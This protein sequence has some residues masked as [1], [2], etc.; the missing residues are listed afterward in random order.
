VS[1]GRLEARA[2]RVHFQGVKAIDGVDLAVDQAEVLGLIGPN[3]AGKTTLVNV[4][5]G[6]QH[7]TTGTVA[8][9]GRDI[10][11]WGPAEIARAGLVRTF[12]GA[13]FFGGLTVFE[14]VE[15]AAVSAGASRRAARALAGELLAEMGIEEKARLPARALSHGEERKL[16]IAR[17]LALRPS[18]LLLDEPA[19]GLDLGAREA[20]VLRLARLAAD[21]TAP[22]IVLVSHH[23][24]EI[25]RGF[26]HA[27]LL[28]GG[29]VISAGRIDETL[30]GSS[31]SESYGLPLQIDRRDGRYAARVAIAVAVG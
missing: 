15:V 24:E 29:R 13:R 22:T 6:F 17:A 5:S 28:A 14:N 8:I 9:S 11:T 2:I 12:Q 16:G 26:T 23:V 21:P 20:L 25:P 18:F 4:L 3:G 10:T 7:A 31:M 30:T 19:A 27:L 1:A